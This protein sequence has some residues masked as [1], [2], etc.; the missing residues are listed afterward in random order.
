MVN[1][2]QK[3]AVSDFSEFEQKADRKSIMSPFSRESKS[4]RRDTN[5]KMKSRCKAVLT[6][7]PKYNREKDLLTIA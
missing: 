3:P 5:N 4:S 2:P 1:S 7:P 6:S